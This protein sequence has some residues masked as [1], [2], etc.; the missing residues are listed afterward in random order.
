M[1]PLTVFHMQV[2][3]SDIIYVKILLCLLAA[4]IAQSV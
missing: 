3:A 1:K 4:G 2:A